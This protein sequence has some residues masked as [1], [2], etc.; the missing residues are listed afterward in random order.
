MRQFIIIMHI[1]NA[2]VNLMV[3]SLVHNSLLK[4][5]HIFS[6]HISVSVEGENRHPLPNR[7]VNLKNL[8]ELKSVAG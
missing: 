8:N 3:L 1:T 4:T 2:L 7:A 6:Q 5:F